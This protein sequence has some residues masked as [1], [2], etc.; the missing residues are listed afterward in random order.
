MKASID[1]A[2]RQHLSAL[3]RTVETLSQD[4]SLCFAVA[5]SER[6]WPIYV[7][8]SRGHEWADEGGAA[9]RAVLDS[10]WDFLIAEADLPAGLSDRIGASVPNDASLT[11]PDG[12]IAHTIAISFMDLVSRVERKQFFEAARF[13]AARNLELIEIVFDETEAE[14]AQDAAL[15]ELESLVTMEV[16]RQN[17]EL[18]RLSNTVDS[19]KRTLFAELRG[20]SETIRLLGGLW[21]P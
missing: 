5:C 15:I 7:R 1:T 6:Q 21:L 3:D 12:V 13:P 17:D 9:I 16:E 4:C 14:D 8:A 20:E 19:Y 2:M 18:N 11:D 10:C